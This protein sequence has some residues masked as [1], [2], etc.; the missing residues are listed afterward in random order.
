MVQ[1]VQVIR[2]SEGISCQQCPSVYSYPWT[3]SAPGRA[4]PYIA[5]DAHLQLHFKL[6]GLHNKW[7][8]GAEELPKTVKATAND[9]LWL[10]DIVLAVA[11][12]KKQ[13]EPTNI[14]LQHVECLTLM[15][16]TG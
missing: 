11:H 12:S 4:T 14:V 7:M 16:S 3:L 6:E 10:Q 2:A 9:P 13:F 15:V 8:A 5:W 1:L